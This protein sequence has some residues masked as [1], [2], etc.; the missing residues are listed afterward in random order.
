MRRADVGGRK[1]STWSGRLSRGVGDGRGV[2]RLESWK[3][4]GRGSDWN[5]R[6]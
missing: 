5:V 3:E 6:S 4:N 1:R 2:A